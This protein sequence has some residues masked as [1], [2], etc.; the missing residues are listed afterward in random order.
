MKRILLLPLLLLM[1]TAH[2]NEA[3]QLYEASGKYYDNQKYDSAVIMGE[4]ALP[5][6]R[7]QG[8][9]KE[10]ADELSILSVCCMRQ[11]EYDKA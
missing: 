2:A 8:M 4:R 10:E 11:S 3:M 5:L 9:K 7:Q 6:L 1:F